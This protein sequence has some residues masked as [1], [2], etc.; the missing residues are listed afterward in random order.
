MR[1]SLIRLGR[2]D[3]GITLVEVLV[4]VSI[5]LVGLVSLLAVMPRSMGHIGQANFRTTAVFLAQE[6][7]EQVK[8]AVWTCFPSYA[9]SQGLSNPATSAPRVSTATCAAPL[10]LTIT[11]N[12]ATVTFP[13][14]GY[15]SIPG[16]PLY[17]RQV[18]IVDCGVAPG[19]GGGVLNSGI[20][21]VTV[22]V[23]FRPLTGEGTINNAIED[24]G[25]MTTFM[26]LR[27]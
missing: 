8:N 16:Y 10:P 21:Q 18:R 14:E 4:A 20:R 3:A 17:R 11:G 25:R 27:Q 15:N 13:D 9:D 12:T 24:V 2:D 23:F 1:R 26:T 22:S 6:R 19:C 5:I 7:L